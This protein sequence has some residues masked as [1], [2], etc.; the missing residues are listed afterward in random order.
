MVIKRRVGILLASAMLGTSLAA[1]PAFAQDAQNQQQL[2]SQINAMQKQLQDMQHKLN[3]ATQQATAAQTQATAAQTAVQNLPSGLYNQSPP[4]AS[5]V[6]TKGGPSFFSTVNVS[7][8]GS[9]IEGASVWRQRN[10]VA[11]GASDPPFTTLPFQNSPLYNENEFRMSAQQS[12]IAIKM[13]GDIDPVQHLKAYFETDFLG[14]GVTANSRESNS[15]NLRLRQ[16]FLEYD[17]D[18]WHFHFV[19]GQAWSLVTQNRVGMLP[20]SENTPLT[21]DAQYVVGFNWTRQPQLRFVEDWNKMVWFGVSVE[22]PQ[23]AIAGTFPTTPTATFPQYVNPANLGTASGLI[24]STTY[25]SNDIAPDIV[26][27][28]AF[29]PGWGHYEAF[30]LERWFADQ[31][32]P[33]TAPFAAASAVPV[34]WRTKTTFGW[35]VGGSVLLPVL[36]KYLDLQGSVMYG[37]GG[38]RYGSSQFADVTYGST[39]A[40]SPLQYLGALVGGVGHPWTGL[41]IYLYAGQ[42]QVNANSFGTTSGYGNAFLAN[43]GCALASGASNTTAAAAAM[44]MPLTGTTCTGNVQRTQEL[45]VGFWQNIYKGPVGRFVFGMQYEFI[46]ANLFGTNCGLPGAAGCVGSVI[47]A[48]N[49]GL[50]VN[51]NIFFTSIRYYPF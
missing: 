22:S 43:N 8:A 23:A 27:K 31:V 15:Y 26:E 33:A 19:G 17:N 14:S 45:T 28:L 12:R 49:A 21:I 5:P 46:H 9:F 11:S 39:G 36:P 20:Q 4:G 1:M 44:N 18:D 35:D 7:F 42:E 34:N 48:P 50:S 37:Q 16:A 40:L 10:E 25:Y 32:A 29:D 47:S 3:Q 41:D 24:D 51:N 13:T 38:G 6:V 2:Q 30:G